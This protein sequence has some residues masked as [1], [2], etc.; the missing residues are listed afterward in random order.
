M[1]K[2]NEKAAQRARI[3]CE[4]WRTYFNQ[5][6]D[7]Y[8]F[9][10]LF[11]FG[12]QWTEDEESDMMK[13]Y[14][15]KAMTSNKITALA[16]NLL[17]EQQQNTPQLQV[18]PG[19]GCDERVASLREIILKDIV[20]S[21]DARTV[22]QMAASQAAIGG[23][24]AFGVGT[25]YLHDKSFD[26]DISMYYFK[27][28]TRCYWDVAAEEKN[29]T[30][31]THCGYISRMS[32]KKFRQVYGKDVEEN[33]SRTF[34]IT[35]TQEEI[36]LEVQPDGSDNPFNWADDESITILNHY[37][38]KQ[39]KD[40]LYELSNGRTLFQDEL[41][42]LIE[43]S[44]KRHEEQ[45]LLQMIH[46][47]QAVQ[48]MGSMQNIEE[49]GVM[50]SENPML[51][52]GFGVTGQHDILPSDN[53]MQSA[54]F[55]PN[56]FVN[57]PEVD[58][59]DEDRLTLWDGDEAVRIERKR[60]ANR[61]YIVHSQFAG[62]YEL[63]KEDFPSEQ[64]PI[65][66][67][68]NDSYFDKVGKQ[69]CRSFFDGCVD[70][71]RYINYLRTQSAYMLQ[72]SRYDQWIGSKKNVASLDTRR[73]WSDPTAIQ[74]MLTYDESPSGVKPEQI[75]PPE[76]SASLFQQYQLAVDDLYSTTGLYPAQMGN[77]GDE[78]SGR[79]I[80]ARTRQGSYSTT[81][82]RNSIDL[83]VATCGKIVNEMIPKVYDTERVLRLVMPDKGMQ[84]ITI[85]KQLDAYGERIENDI[86]KGTYQVILKPGP[87]YEGQKEQ[88]LAS[89]QQVLQADPTSWTL[90]ADL[91]AEN[92]PLANTIEIKNRLKTRVPPEIVEAGKTGDMPQQQG[93]NPEQQALQLQAQQQQQEMA[94]KAQELQ[95]KQQDIE[96]KKQQAIMDMQ[97]RIQELEN[98]RL[99]VA[100]EIKEQEL[101]YLAETQR[102]ESDK[103]IAHAENLVKI[104]THNPGLH[105]N[106][107]INK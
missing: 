62:D 61:Y 69:F 102:T 6:I 72:V 101:R 46:S 106:K 71:Q 18:L 26:V 91:Y 10:H 33:I 54:A 11:V 9:M 23:F 34:G 2:K 4:K 90:I 22:Y 94:F 5:N 82:F 63:D 98:E 65:V 40:T 87:S 79:A 66:F 89:L 49:G 37:E 80:N 48:G 52:D 25:E 70:I 107:Q 38:R 47:N 64:L 67:V 42:A 86:R 29:K 1:A 21:T 12:R 77:A 14:R 19:A 83:A 84:E 50:P 97:M 8:H 55:N 74:G 92:L 15:K 99:E 78:A 88:A 44:K 20:L 41:D 96:L 32:R 103:S 58:E 57:A 36:A 43:K 76:L 39:R 7:N 100:G 24:G 45:V 56:P 81:V 105:V 85:N 16:N 104:L 59:L 30:D 73:N 27:D 3:A 51:E 17:G 35:Q 13:T 93:P 28:A 31:G 75:R 95:L 53:G 68:D 60:P